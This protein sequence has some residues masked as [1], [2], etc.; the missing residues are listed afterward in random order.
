MNSFAP[1]C[2]LI[3]PSPASTVIVVEPDGAMKTGARRLSRGS[4]IVPVGAAVVLAFALVSCGHD[5]T[6]PTAPSTSFG[7]SPRP[8]VPRPELFVPPSVP[9]GGPRHL[10]VH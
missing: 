3:G 9:P 4:F 2:S 5:E 6:A 8:V 1:L 7:P 10:G